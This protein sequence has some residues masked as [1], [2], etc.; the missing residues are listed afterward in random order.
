MWD[1]F[2]TAKTWKWAAQNLRLG[3]VLDIADLDTWGKES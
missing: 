2:T 3:R 1:T